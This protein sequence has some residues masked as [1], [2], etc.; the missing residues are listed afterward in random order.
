[1]IAGCTQ[2][3]VGLTFKDGDFECS[4]GESKIEFKPG[5]AFGGD[6]SKLFAM[7]SD[8]T[9]DREKRSEAAL[10]A[11]PDELRTNAL[12]DDA[13]LC[14]DFLSRASVKR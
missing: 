11:L 2:T 12:R 3:E 9:D 7:F 4:R 13:S 14:A 10:R 5:E 8:L 1:M 6:L